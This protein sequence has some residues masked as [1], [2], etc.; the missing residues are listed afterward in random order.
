MFG[1]EFNPRVAMDKRHTDLIA[2]TLKAIG[3]VYQGLEIG[4]GSGASLDAM[5]ATEACARFTLVDNWLLEEGELPSAATVKE[6]LTVQNEGN[7]EVKRT[8]SY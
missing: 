7:R 3:P 2:A 8:I 6:S 4:L 5:L 1:L